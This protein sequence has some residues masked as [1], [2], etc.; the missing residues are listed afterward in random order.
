MEGRSIGHTYSVMTLL[1]TPTRKSKGMS[2]LVKASNRSCAS[3]LLNIMSAESSAV[4]DERPKHSW[5][6]TDLPP[7]P[8]S[9]SQVA[10]P[11]SPH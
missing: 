7:L 4:I 9:V 2:L 5:H 3:R 10:C 6:C 11:K 1:T 8:D